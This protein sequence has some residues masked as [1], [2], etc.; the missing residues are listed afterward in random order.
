[1]TGTNRK[2][3]LRITLATIVTFLILS[4]SSLTLAIT[5]LGGLESIHSLSRLFTKQTSK[6]IVDKIN[7][8]FSSAEESGN[9]TSF[10][11][12]SGIVDPKNEYKCLELATFVLSQN[13]NIYSVNIAT[14]DGSKY[15][16]SR[17]TN[18][19][20][21]QRSDIRTS[22]NIVRK[23]YSEDNALLE[24]NKNTISSFEKGYDARKRP[25]FKKAIESQASAWTDIYESSSDRQFVYSFTKPIYDK[26]QQ[27]LAVMAIDL[28]V[29]GLS[30]FLSEMNLF[31][32]GKSFIVND[33]KQIIAYPTKSS[34]DLEEK[35]RIPVLG[36]NLCLFDSLGAELIVRLSAKGC[37]SVADKDEFTHEL[38]STLRARRSAGGDTPRCRT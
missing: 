18:G 30:Q 20:I 14:P 37:L 34:I 7:R 11:I 31:E 17:E 10:A 29:T 2:F 13:P 38:R 33:R 25:W 24:N 16:A 5:Y 35:Q 1:M 8:L 36:E 12:G 28:E 23:Y 4:V 3:T 15:K 22:K 19:A 27:L 32:G 21:L 6:G 9:I 26:K